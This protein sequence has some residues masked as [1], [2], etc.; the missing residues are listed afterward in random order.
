[1]ADIFSIVTGTAG[2][3]DT[4]VR[5]TVYIKE[6]RKDGAFIQQDLDAL[7]SEVVAL[8]QV[9]DAISSAFDKHASM[10]QAHQPKSDNAYTSN[11]NDILWKALGRSIEHCHVIVQRI[12][13]ILEA[14]CQ[15]SRLSSVKGLDTIT[16]VRR[17][18]SKEEDLRRCRSELAMHHYSIQM[19]LTLINREDTQISFKEVHTELHSIQSQISS[20]SESSI[21]EGDPY[22]DKEY[23]R[24]ALLALRDL[25]RSIT[26]VAKIVSPPIINEHF[27]TPQTVSS[28]FTGRDELLQQLK[29][30]FIQPPGPPSSQSQRRFVI[31]GLGGSGKTQFCCKFAEANRHRFWGVFWVDGSSVQNIEKTFGN[32]AKLAGRDPSANAAIDWLSIIE[33]RWL[34]LID[35][36]DDPSVRL[37]DYFPRGSGGHILIT[38]RNQTFR[39]LGTIGPKYYSFSGLQSEEASD[40]LL[41]AT[42]LPLPWEPDLKSSASKVIE[43]L[44]CLALAIVQAGAAI[45]ARLCSVHDYLGWYDRT[46]QKLRND[47]VVPN[48][49]NE[50]AAWTTFELCYERL[51]RERNR[52]EAADAIELLHLFAFFYRENV[53]PAMLTRALRNAHLEAEQEKKDTAKEERDLTVREMLQRK[54]TSLLMVIIGKATPTPLPTVVRDGRQLGGFELAEDRIRCALSELETMS[55]IYFNEGSQT[56]SMHPVIHD[57]ARKRPRMKLGYQALWADMA[58]YVLSASILLPPLGTKQEDELYNSTLSPHID[59]VRKCRADI[60][61]QMRLKPR[62]RWFPWVARD[63]TTMATADRIRMSAKFALVY[64]QCGQMENAETLLKDVVASLTLYLGPENPKVRSAQTALSH[65]YWE[66]G[67][68]DG[69]LN[70]QES[71]ASVCERHFGRDNPET[72][73]ALHKLSRTLWQQGKYSAAKKLQIE[74]VEGLTKHLGRER[75]DTLEALDDFGRTVAKFWRQEDLQEA[76]NLFSEALEGLQRS[77]GTEHLR[78]TYVK[79]NIARTSCLI[80]GEDLLERALHFMDEVITV[81]KARM[82]K[83][84]GWTLMALGNQ[85]VVL[86]AMGKLSEAEQVML[87]L[88]PIAKRTIGTEHIGVLFGQQILATIWIQQG[89]YNKAERSLLEVAEGQKRMTSRRENYHPDRIGTLIELARCYQLQGKLAESIKVCDEAIQGLREITTNLHPFTEM[90]TRARTQMAE[91]KETQDREQET[92]LGVIDTI[93]KFPEHLFKLYI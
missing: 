78:T 6:I 89:H 35:N 52:R 54:F 14:I 73:R 82:G 77:L 29:D 83:E 53:S 13:N 27:H 56:Y 30:A 17:K 66:R 45:R 50:Q 87:D 11:A 34:L 93:V 51:E 81:R 9:N 1:M 25:E 69:A 48:T 8:Q 72:L 62:T 76:L 92:G 44:G 70:L 58:G 85:A 37:E 59:E 68:V 71:I 20:F 65:I 61:S 42:C 28:I 7:L 2:L 46:W 21:P 60:Q 63:T 26:E 15:K 33:Q 18:R 84:A 49:G 5:L 91:L 39:Y 12:Y 3:L 88:L 86:A 79:E 32:I 80:G 57:W 4:C 43:A 36:A 55:L 40:L 10:R 23:D 47:N 90:L 64:A 74:V 41:K 75:T 22:Y 19:F 16:K 67:N 38:T 31:H 24:E